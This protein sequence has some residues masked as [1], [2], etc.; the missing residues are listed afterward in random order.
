MTIRSTTRRICSLLNDV[1][2]SDESDWTQR[3]LCHTFGLLF[4]TS[5]TFCDS[6]HT[7]ARLVTYLVGVL[8]VGSSDGGKAYHATF[9]IV[10]TNC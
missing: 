8:F 10:L 1:K 9:R 6:L 4:K 2:S 3:R 5:T 7:H